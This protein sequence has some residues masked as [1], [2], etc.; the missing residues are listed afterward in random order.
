LTR[1]S[2]WRRI[3]IEKYISL[4]NAIEWIRRIR[5][6]IHNVSNQW[7]S[8]TLVFPFIGQFLAWKVGSWVQVKVGI[9]TILGCGEGIFLPKYLILYLH[10]Q[11]RCKL[12]KFDNPLLSSVWS[13]GWLQ[14]QALGLEGSS[15]QCWDGLLAEIRKEHVR[16]MDE[17]DEISWD[18]N[19]TRGFYTAKLR[20]KNLQTPEV[21]YIC[22]S[23]KKL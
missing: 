20:Y 9:D 17:D 16:L 10:E 13:Q 3:L 15:S 6:N 4:A 1:D 21:K 11:G 5:K 12:N 7:K 23:W 8:L 18:Y 2:L 19:K 22:W 14:D